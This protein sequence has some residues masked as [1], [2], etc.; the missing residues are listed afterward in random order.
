VQTA[1]VHSEEE[2]LSRQTQ[3][4]YL[5]KE[6]HERPFVF[7]SYERDGY[8]KFDPSTIFTSLQN[9]ETSLFEPLSQEPSSVEKVTDASISWT[10]ADYLEI[11]SAL[12][13]LVWDDS[14]DPMVWKIY[15]VS[16]LV[17]CIDETC[18]FDNADIV[19]FKISANSYTTRIMRIQPFLGLARWGDGTS[20]PPVRQWEGVELTTARI[21]AE[22]ALKI[23]EENGGRKLRLKADNKCI[24]SV[25]SPA[26]GSSGPNNRNWYVQYI[27]QDPPIYEFFIDFDSGKYEFNEM[28]GLP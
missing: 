28:Y 17:E 15:D 23:A 26:L 10:Q 5:Y 21:T 27:F 1:V 6:Y 14:M 25:S 13:A 22:D 2:L 9:G 7:N 12:S 20:Y 11:F 19:Y 18:I 8:Y 4:A 24:M 16:F 3:D